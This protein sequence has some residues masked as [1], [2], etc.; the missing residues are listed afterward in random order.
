MPEHVFVETNFVVDWAAPAHLCVAEA[1][2]LVERAQRDEI[3]LHIP[4]IC[5][6]EAR[7][8][9]RSERFQPKS[10][11]NPIRQFLHGPASVLDADTRDAAF[12]ALTAYEQHMKAALADVPARIARLRATA[13][14][15]VF[16]AD[17]E[18]LERGIELTSIVERLQPYDL[19]VLASV[20]VRAEQLRRGGAA[21]PIAFCER[22]SDLQ[23]W[24]REGVP[25]RWLQT[26]YDAAHVRVFEDFTMTTPERPAA[27]SPGG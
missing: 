5:L 9:L 13:G 2:A 21:G 17:D 24:D 18:I 22:D 10:D 6:L 14:V 4:A 8:V 1:V 26:L 23:P 16:P 27:W 3:A 15:H 12:R 7:H 20:L 11:A 19:N 25:K